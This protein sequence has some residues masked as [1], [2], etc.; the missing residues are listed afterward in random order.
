MTNTVIEVYEYLDSIAPFELQESYDNAGL[1]VGDAQAEVTGVMLCLDSTEAILDEAIEKGCN[2]IIA[3]HPIVFRGLKQ[4]VG[5]NYIQRTIIKAI[6]NDIA[7]IAIHTNLDNVL[8]NGVNEMIASKLNMTNISILAPKDQDV[9]EEVVGAGIV[10]KLTDKMETKE[11]FDFLKQQMQLSVIKH[12][13][14]CYEKVRKIA[15]CGG[16]GGFLLE[17]AKAAG[18]Q[19]FVTS[20]YKYHEF[21]DA[22]GD[23][24]I[25]DIGHFES[26]QYTIEL[27][28]KLVKEKFS[29]FAAHYTLQS[30]NPVYYY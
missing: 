8:T 2:L 7:I 28:Y 15:I 20:D 16:S 27:L 3:H 22:D 29:T 21:F 17:H 25:A 12:T 24:I 4:F 6:K 26:E 23:I 10:G 19:V 1:I 9:T 13:N 18:A 14:I 5:D 30:T 11:F